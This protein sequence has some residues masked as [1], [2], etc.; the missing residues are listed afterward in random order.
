[1]LYFS[2]GSNMSQA[3]L[4][5]RAPS[6]VKV[7]TGSLPYHD[8]R[9]HKISQVD[10]SAKC[11]ALETGDPEHRVLGVVY[12]I[13]ATDKP[14]LDRAEGLGIGYGQKEVIIELS[15]GGSL[16]AFT[17]YATLI[18]PGL[19]PLDWYREHVLRGAREHGLPRD[20]V[21]RLEAVETVVDADARRRRRELS[22]YPGMEEGS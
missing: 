11:D 13:A 18:D 5:A 22:I 1:M 7:A 6:A 17:Y 8:L 12:E 20:Y 15:G 21:G 14:L 10:G 16:V 4:R 3:R 2:Y 9:F 19:R